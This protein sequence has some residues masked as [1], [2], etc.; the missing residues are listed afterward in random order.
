MGQLQEKVSI[1]TQA[2]GTLFCDGVLGPGWVR[3][4]RKRH[5]ELS[6]RKPQ[7][8]E[9][10]RA[11]NL[12]PEVVASFYENLKILYN[13]NKYE[14]HQIWN[15]DESGAQA[16]RDGGAYVI[17]KRGT[18]SVVKVAPECREWISVLSCI[19]ASGQSIPNFYI[20]R[21][22]Y[23]SRNFIR[24]TGEVSAT[25]A[26]STKAWMTNHLFIEWMLHFLLILE[27]K[28]NISPSNRHLL[29]LDGHGSHMTMKVIK[30]AMDRDLDMVTI[31]SRTSHCL[32][33]L[34]I[35]CFKPFK[36]F[37]RAYPDKWNLEYKRHAS[38]KEDLAL[39][40]S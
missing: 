35:C 31:P 6:L 28:Y 38:T 17:V 9:Q 7:A 11:K 16:S 14:G 32:Q 18:K 29:I 33:P 2:R 13:R 1:L 23:K 26:M 12:C 21:G 15:C 8:L 3:C 22:K 30:I 34:D 20:F 10:N 40:I 27:E 5:L 25:M 19:N 24:G 4:F 37:F 36:L 39:W